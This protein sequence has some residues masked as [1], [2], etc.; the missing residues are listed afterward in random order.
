MSGKSK[1]MGSNC[2]QEKYAP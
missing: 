2:F 1:L